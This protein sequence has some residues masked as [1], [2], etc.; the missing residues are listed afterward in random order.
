VLAQ[1]HAP[2]DRRVRGE[3][4]ADADVAR[5]HR[6][7]GRAHDDHDVAAVADDELGGEPCFVAQALEDRPGEVGDLERGDVLE[8][9]AHHRGADA[10]AVAL[11]FEEAEALE[12][13]RKAERGGPRDP[14]LARHGRAAQHAMGAVEELQ[15]LEPPLQAW[16][17]V[18]RGRFGHGVSV[19]ALCRPANSAMRAFTRS[20]ASR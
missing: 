2:E 11:A 1:Q 3:P 6:L 12:R 9:E 4:R 13:L 7:A 10:E 16:H 18:L 8:A 14:E 15:E 17:V 19:S 5:E 20:G